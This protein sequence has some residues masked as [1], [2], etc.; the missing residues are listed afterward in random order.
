MCPQV[1]FGK[2]SG[3]HE[4]ECMAAQVNYYL[5]PPATEKKVFHDYRWEMQVIDQEQVI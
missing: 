1:E 2:L 5:L 3:I 4:V